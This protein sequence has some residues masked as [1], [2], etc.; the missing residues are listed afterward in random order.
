MRHG[1]PFEADVRSAGHNGCG[2][3]L[4]SCR[5]SNEKGRASPTPTAPNWAKRGAA[6]RES[7]GPRASTPDDPNLPS[8]RSAGE[9]SGTPSSFFYA[10]TVVCALLSSDVIMFSTNATSFTARFSRRH[11]VVDEGVQLCI[12]SLES[13]RQLRRQGSWDAP[14]RLPAP[15]GRDALPNG[16]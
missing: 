4:C 9:P 12:D 3:P 7:A 1:K 2:L 11:R 8:L 13:R 5:R 15:G 10:G 16:S 14:Q 6:G